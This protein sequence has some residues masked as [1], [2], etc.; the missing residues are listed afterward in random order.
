MITIIV[1]AWTAMLPRLT[2][3]PMISCRSIGS[4]CPKTADAGPH[5]PCGLFGSY[6]SDD[7]PLSNRPPEF[8][9]RAPQG[10]RTGTCQIAT[11]G[12]D[13]YQPP[14]GY[15]RLAPT[16]SASTSL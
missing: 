6:R 13:G 5:G 11:A 10:L 16:V 8:I 7:Q 3:P 9:V 2:A 15:L 12:R 1:A 14:P 4:T